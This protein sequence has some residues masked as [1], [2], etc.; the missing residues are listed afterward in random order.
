M[1]FERA[2]LPEPSE[3]TEGFW[4]A[5]RR[6]ELVVQRCSTCAALRHYPQ[7][8]CPSC[9]SPEWAWTPLSGRG[10]V[11]SYTV[12]HRGFNASWTERLPYALVTVELEEGVRMVSDLPD[13]QTDD[14]EIGRP[15]EVFFEDLDGVT[16]PRFRL[17]AD[18]GSAR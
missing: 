6:H 9:L 14:V 16:L 17:V 8:R 3:L 12:T 10:H 4:E 18:S 5:A 1:T 11:F 7:H 13:E 2:P 15:V